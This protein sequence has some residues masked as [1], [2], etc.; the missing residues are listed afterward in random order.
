MLREFL[1]IVTE[2]A[3]LWWVLENVP[4]VPDVQIAGYVVQR[5]NLFACEFGLKQQRN[6]A[7]QFGYRDGLK[8]VLSRGES[9]QRLRP[10]AMATDGSH[11]RRRSFAD[12]CEL[13]GLPRN[14]DLPGLSRS[15]KFRA[16]GNGVPV[17]VAKSLAE[18]IRDRRLTQEVRVC[19]CDCGRPVTGKQIAATA[20]C[21]KRLERRRLTS[22]SQLPGP[23]TVD[24]TPTI[25][26]GAAREN[27]V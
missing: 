15:A 5:F 20:A 2:A 10:A 24:F 27:A 18:A 25:H 11:G 12:F 21:R 8:L 6:R 26:S 17:P 14:F 3:P 22:A 9:Q 4:C 23:L 7:I 1:R 16:I 19:K 13:Q